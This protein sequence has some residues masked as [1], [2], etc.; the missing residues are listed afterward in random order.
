MIGAGHSRFG[1][2]L[3]GQLAKAPLHPVADDGIADLLRDGEAEAHGLDR[4][5]RAAGRGGRSRWSRAQS[6][7]GREEIPRGA[8]A[9]DPARSGAVAGFD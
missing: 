8:E 7:V 5:R 2:D 1:E 9:F 3:P 6:M 4:R